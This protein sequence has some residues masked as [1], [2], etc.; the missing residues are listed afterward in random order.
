MTTSS[1]FK[2]GLQNDSTSIGRCIQG[3]TGVPIMEQ[4]SQGATQHS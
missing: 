3:Q 1:M 4:G 2:G